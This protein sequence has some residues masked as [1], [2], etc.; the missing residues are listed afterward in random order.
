MSS[1]KIFI[2]CDMKMYRFVG[3]SPPGHNSDTILNM[4]EPKSVVL[5][6]ERSKIAQ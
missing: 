1:I 4:G 6:P 3:Y 2:I 5:I